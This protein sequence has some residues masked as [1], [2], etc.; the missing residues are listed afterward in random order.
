MA[1]A[2]ILHRVA[3]YDA[4]RKVYDSVADMQKDGGVT[5]ESVHR[6]ADDPDNVLVIHEFESVAAAKAFFAGANLKDAMQ[7]GGVQGEPRIELFE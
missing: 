1:I 3:D 7:R 4:W 6:M 5:K 2:L